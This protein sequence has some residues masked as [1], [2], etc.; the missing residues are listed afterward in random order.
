[1]IVTYAAMVFLAFIATVAIGIM[2][3]DRAGTSRDPNRPQITASQLAIIETM[4]THY[5]QLADE[6]LVQPLNQ[7]E[8]EAL[9]AWDAVLE[10]C[11]G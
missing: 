10:V 3:Y 8:V 6:G 11:L 2:H 9:A 7:H 5:R 4:M 1:M